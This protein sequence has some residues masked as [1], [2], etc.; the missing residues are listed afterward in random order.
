MFRYNFHNNEL[1]VLNTVHRLGSGRLE[2][3]YI[4]EEELPYWQSLHTVRPEISD[5]LTLCLNHFLVPTS[6]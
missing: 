3:D 6:R 2:G 5:S 1:D 4:T